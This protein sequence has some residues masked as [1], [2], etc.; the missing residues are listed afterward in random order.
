ML[1]P[2]QPLN[3][4]E[5]I[6][7]LRSYRILDSLPEAS[8]DG[9]TRVA[10][11]VAGVPYALVSLVDET[12]QWFKSK[13][14]MDVEE[15]PREIAFCAHAILS[16]DRPLIVPDALDD[17]RFA[18]NPLVTGPAG[19][20]FY[21]GFP[22]VTPSGHALGTLCVLGPEPT[23]L[24]DAD[25]DAL[26][27]LAQQVVAL[28]E[29]RRTSEAMAQALERVRALRELIPICSHCKSLRDE[30]GE[31]EGDHWQAVEQFLRAHGAELS[32][33]ICPSCLSREYGIDAP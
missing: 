30:G 17:P 8:F 32:H 7:V 21:A 9:I 19:L 4:S 10:S 11:H 12:R 14:G 22:L 3:E 27:V 31:G 23:T 28:L 16:P 1:R 2:A 26:G 13:V 33:G 24:A 6:E 25:R 15:T 5:R 29:L 18:D 20:R